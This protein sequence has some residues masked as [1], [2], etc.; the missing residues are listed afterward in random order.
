MESLAVFGFV[1]FWIVVAGTMLFVALGRRKGKSRETPSRVRRTQR[2]AILAFALAVVV[3]GVGIPAAVIATVN[4]RESIP[5]ANVSNL[6]AA[7]QRGRVLFGQR[8]KNCHALKAA[9][10]TANVG[11]N[12]DALRPPYN[13]V[14]DAIEKGRARGNGQMAADLVEGEDANAV[15]AFVAKAT[16]QTTKR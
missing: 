11:P 5:E 6:T 3:L 2:I 13:L 7:E 8:C 16:G 12:L 1:A 10:A 9:N 4:E 14:M 15:A